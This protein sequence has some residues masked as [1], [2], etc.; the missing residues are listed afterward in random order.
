MR[1]TMTV[2]VRKLLIGLVALT[3]F[4]AGC[5]AAA[6]PTPTTAAPTPTPLPTATR[7]PTSTPARTISALTVTSTAF[8]PGG[9]IP[10]KHTCDGTTG[11][12]TLLW[13]DAPST[14][15]SYALIMDDPDATSGVFTHW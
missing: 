5:T 9:T 12:P 8:E 15:K 3:S 13:S 14:T 10:I 1:W 11:S 6:T 7:A 2:S 4:F